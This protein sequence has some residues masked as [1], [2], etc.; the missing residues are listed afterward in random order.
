MGTLQERL[1][2]NARFCFFSFFFLFFFISRSRLEKMDSRLIILVLLYPVAMA[3]GAVMK[4]HLIEAAKRANS[5]KKLGGKDY[6]AAESTINIANNQSVPCALNWKLMDVEEALKQKN[7]SITKTG[8]DGTQVCSIQGIFDTVVKQIV[9]DLQTR[10]FNTSSKIMGLVEVEGKNYVYQRNSIRHE[11]YWEKRQEYCTYLGGK[12]AEDITK[13][14]LDVLSG[15]MRFTERYATAD[16]AVGA[17]SKSGSS[18]ERSTYKWVNG[19]A[20]EENVWSTAITWVSFQ[21][22]PK[23]VLFFPGGNIK[24]TSGLKRNGDMTQ[25]FGGLCQ[26]D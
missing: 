3:N 24:G 15:V 26:I 19:N 9:T 14:D 20:I 7:D 17:E 18:N 23:A 1:S 10:T 4:N 25:I 12:L 2:L 11:D 8:V 21:R 22:G 16:Y 13:A 6:I 5:Y